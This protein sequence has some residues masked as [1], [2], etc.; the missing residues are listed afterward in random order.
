MALCFYS[1]VN[2]YFCFVQTR[3]RNAHT[4]LRASDPD[5][6]GAAIHLIGVRCVHVHLIGVLLFPV[7]LIEGLAVVV[8]LLLTVSE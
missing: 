6:V 7:E 3:Q 1:L 5:S 2:V 4:N 8:C